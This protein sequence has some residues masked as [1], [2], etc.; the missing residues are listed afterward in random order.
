MDVV[1]VEVVVVETE[2]VVQLWFFIFFRR[3]CFGDMMDVRVGMEVVMGVVVLVRVV[4]LV[5]WRCSVV[6]EWV[7][8]SAV[9]ETEERVW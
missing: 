9:L 1:V 8:G 3:G 2:D 6:G 5:W 4:V 7:W